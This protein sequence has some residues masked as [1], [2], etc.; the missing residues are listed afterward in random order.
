VVLGVT[1][2]VRDPLEFA[3]QLGGDLLAGGELLL[4]EQAGLDALGQVNL[5]LCVEERDLS[6]LLEVVLDR[7]RSGTSGHDLLGWRVVVAGGHHEADGV[8]LGLFVVFV[9]V[10]VG[11]GDHCNVA[12]DG[13]GVGLRVVNDG[14]V[15]FGIVEL[16]VVNDLELRLFGLGLA[17]GGSCL[18]GGR[19]RLLE[20]R[21]R[22]VPARGRTTL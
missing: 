20:N 4:R 8:L 1:A 14:R 3:A 9:L 19:G 22:I 16:G 5:L 18:S 10:V 7:V 11:L 12:S 15:E 17:R 21:G 13:G 2:V 6:D